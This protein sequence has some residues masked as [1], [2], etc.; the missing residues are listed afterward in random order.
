MLGKVCLC[1]AQLVYLF[2]RLCYH[3]VK[4]IRE[5][6]R[7]LLTGPSLS[8]CRFWGGEGRWPRAEVLGWDGDLGLENVD[9]VGRLRHA[10]WP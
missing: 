3:Q 7:I 1:K 4:A 2:I 8:T 5:H 9:F 10:A 6:Y